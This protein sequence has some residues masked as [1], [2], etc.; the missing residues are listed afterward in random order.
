M[1]QIR[2][3]YSDNITYEISLV[4]KHAGL[5]AWWRITTYDGNG[6][7]DDVHILSFYDVHLDNYTR[8]LWSPDK[9][10]VAY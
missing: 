7:N 1:F 5:H 2:N 8:S 3:T 9:V 6:D 10:Q 4:A